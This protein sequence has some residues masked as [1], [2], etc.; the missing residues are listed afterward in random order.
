MCTRTA[1]RTCAE[2]EAAPQGKEHA[3]SHERMHA[4]AR[5][6]VHGWKG[7]EDVTS[8]FIQYICVI[9]IFVKV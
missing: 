6:H 5:A 3:H 7:G 4:R 2:I 1:A 9:H 8:F